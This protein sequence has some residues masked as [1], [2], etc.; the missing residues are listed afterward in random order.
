MC[1]Q[2]RRR[3]HPL[4]LKGVNA[5]LIVE[6]VTETCGSGGADVVEYS[7]VSAALGSL[8]RGLREIFVVV[9]VGININ[10]EW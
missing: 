4:P 10:N 5:G 1:T 7:P 2:R 6:T 3:L 9:V 8:R